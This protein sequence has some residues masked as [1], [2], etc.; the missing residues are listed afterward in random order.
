MPV[1]QPLGLGHKCLHRCTSAKEMHAAS[2]GGRQYLRPFVTL[3][4]GKPPI[5]LCVSSVL[6]QLFCWHRSVK[7]AKKENNR[8]WTNSM[9]LISFHLLPCPLQTQKCPSPSYC[10]FPSLR[11]LSLSDAAFATDCA[12]GLVELTGGLGKLDHVI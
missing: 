8:I 2:W 7:V 4:W 10:P 3:P 11:C 1:L 5:S 9:P 6:H 12:G